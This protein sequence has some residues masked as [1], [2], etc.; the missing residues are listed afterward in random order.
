MRQDRAPAHSLWHHKHSGGGL[1]AKWQP[2]YAGHGIPTFPV[3]I[4]GKD[5]KPAVSNYL[6]LGLGTS[7]KLVKRFRN[8]DALGFAVRRAG[9]TVLDIGLSGRPQE[10]QRA[11][12]A[13]R[14]P[15]G[16]FARLPTCC[17]SWLRI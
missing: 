11:R 13:Q 8:S 5:K 2:R 1:F 14:I 10:Q 3:R 17:H 4:V 16:M 7:A 6:G 12:R 9:I 15:E